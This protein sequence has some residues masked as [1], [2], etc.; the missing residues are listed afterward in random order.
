[1]HV[2]DPEEIPGRVATWLGVKRRTAEVVLRQLGFR[3]VEG[4]WRA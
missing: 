3:R 1:M 2:G 4:A